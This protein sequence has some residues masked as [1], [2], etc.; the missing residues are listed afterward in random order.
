MIA[1]GSFT[2]RETLKTQSEPDIM[3]G[4]H[5][6]ASRLSRRGPEEVSEVRGKTRDFETSDAKRALNGE[7]RVRSSPCRH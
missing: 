7:F 4:A 1:N 2:I 5:F 6:V 3:A